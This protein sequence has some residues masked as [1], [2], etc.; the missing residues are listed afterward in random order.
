MTYMCP[1]CGWGG[2]YEPSHDRF[3]GGSFE[4]CPCCGVE[5]GYHDSTK[6]HSVLREEW[7]ANGARWHAND[8]PPPA[9]WSPVAQL[10]RAGH[11]EAAAE[12]EARQPQAAPAA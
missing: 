4:I 1:V 8:E 3:G 6:S 10:R 9:A 5:F 11:F 2:L 7:I 12:L